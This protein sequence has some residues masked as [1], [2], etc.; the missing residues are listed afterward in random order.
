VH[1]LGFPDFTARDAAIR[2]PEEGKE[3]HIQVR[4]GPHTFIA[5]AIEGNYPNYR[6]VIPH[7]FL[8]NA[9]IPESQRPALIT[10]LRSMESKGDS[11]RLTWKNPGHLT[12]TLTLRDSDTP[13]AQIH[14]PVSITGQPPAI[15]FK[16]K[17]LADA[18]AIGSTLR[19]IDGMS[20]IK[21]TDPSGSFC[22]LTPW[23]CVAEDAAE[24]A[25]GHASA[26]G[27][28]A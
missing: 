9:T 6:Q 21:A 14:V 2:Q 11:V 23:R 19:L 3:P 7:E 10:W 16:P 25:A 17:V 22:V 27:V 8:A 26:P 4:S 1:V 15:S 18:L 20:P 24:S 12:L 13:G 5:R 28:A